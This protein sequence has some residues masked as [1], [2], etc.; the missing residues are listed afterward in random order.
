M[1]FSPVAVVQQVH[2]RQVTH[3]TRSNST[4]NQTQ[5][6]K[7]NI[8][9]YPTTMNKPYHNEFIKLITCH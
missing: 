7:H 3:I 8:K 5:Y 9:G 4:F 2:N 1:G 6:T